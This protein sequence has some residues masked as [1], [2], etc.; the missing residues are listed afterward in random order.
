MEN[1]HIVSSKGYLILRNML[2]ICNQVTD[3]QWTP[4]LPSACY[5]PQVAGRVGNTAA[6]SLLG[7]V[8]LGIIRDEHK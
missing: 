2:S 8:L 6:K 1:S 3:S 4:S 5:I 7:I